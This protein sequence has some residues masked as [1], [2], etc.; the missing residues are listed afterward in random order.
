MNSST[1]KVLRLI[2]T[3]LGTYLVSRELLAP[4]AGEQFAD[5]ALVAL[6]ALLPLAALFSSLL[7][8][9]FAALRERIALML[10]NDSTPAT[11]DE[12]VA[13]NFAGTGFF[14]KLQTL[15]RHPATQVGVDV[16]RQTVPGGVLAGRVINAVGDTHGSASDL[17]VIDKLATLET[18]ALSHESRL[19]ALEQ[20]LFPSARP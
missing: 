10:P 20:K 17:S 19:R 5:Y 11:L 9:R 3:M 15:L 18:A 1:A 7:G 2:L 13:L 14:G 16:A 8:G 12:A 4:G 6:G